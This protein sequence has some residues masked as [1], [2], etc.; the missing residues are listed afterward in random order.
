MNFPHLHLVVKG[1]KG[2]KLNPEDYIN[3]S[4]SDTGA[5]GKREIKGTK[6]IGIKCDSSD[7]DIFTFYP[8]TDNSENKL[9]L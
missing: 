9:T 4:V 1:E 7:D 2:N 6:I 3:G 8:I 5:N